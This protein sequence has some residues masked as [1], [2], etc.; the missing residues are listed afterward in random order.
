MSPS[1][2]PRNAGFFARFG[3]FVAVAL[4]VFAAFFVF[5]SVARAEVVSAPSGVALVGRVGTASDVQVAI[6]VKV[7]R[8]TVSRSVGSDVLN[9]VARVVPVVVPT[10]VEIAVDAPVHRNPSVVPNGV[11]SSHVVGPVGIVAVRT[12]LV[13]TRAAVA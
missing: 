4:A 5:V 3:F 10:V 9:L 8:S 12:E 7:A 2:F 1:F 11:S 13:H 6:P